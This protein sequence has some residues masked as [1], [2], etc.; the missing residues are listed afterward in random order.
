MMNQTRFWMLSPLLDVLGAGQ[1]AVNIPA[2]LAGARTSDAAAA[3]LVPIASGRGRAS[4]REDEADSVTRRSSC[5]PRGRDRHA[6]AEQPLCI[7]KTSI[8]GHA[9][10]EPPRRGRRRHQGMLSSGLFV[11]YQDRMVGLRI[12]LSRVTE[13]SKIR[14]MDVIHVTNVPQADFSKVP[15][16]VSQTIV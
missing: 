3:L 10:A 11:R 1:Q 8:A 16:A 9:E 4:P 7:A 12:N 5:A 13:I 6:C 2:W 15:Q 14:D